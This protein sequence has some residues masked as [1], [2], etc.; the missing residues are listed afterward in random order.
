MSAVG[1]GLRGGRLTEWL[2]T[3]MPLARVALLR[4]AVF[5][6]VIVDV[7]WLHT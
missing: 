5:G 4:I 1:D 3:P 2:F 7:L 6:F